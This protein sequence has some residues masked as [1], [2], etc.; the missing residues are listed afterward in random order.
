MSAYIDSL[1]IRIEGAIASDR[2]GKRTDKKFLKAT[3][4]EIRSESWEDGVMWKGGIGTIRPERPLNPYLFD[5]T[6]KR[7]E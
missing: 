2:L 1:V 7:H 6:G 3:L 4:W 5:E